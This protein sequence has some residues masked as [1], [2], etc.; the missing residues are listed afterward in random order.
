ME[1]SITLSLLLAPMKIVPN[2]VKAESTIDI[3][4]H[5]Q[6][7]FITEWIRWEMAQ[8]IHTPNVQVDIP[9]T[10][11]QVRK[12]Y[13]VPGVYMSA[14]EMLLGQSY[15]STGNWICCIITILIS[16]NIQMLIIFCSFRLTQWSSS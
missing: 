9:N 12:L 8:M 14:L 15:S 10:D 4:K 5:T 16:H 13:K 2:K 11:K 1:E 7:W 6:W 3:S